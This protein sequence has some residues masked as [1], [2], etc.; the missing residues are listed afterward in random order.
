MRNGTHEDC[1]DKRN[2]WGLLT[3]A[4]HRARA[5]LVT[6]VVCSSVLIAP[7]AASAAVGNRAS[8]TSSA[9]SIGV[10][11]PVTTLQGSIPSWASSGATVSILQLPNL[12]N[13]SVGVAIPVPTVGDEQV[14]GAAY[15]VSVPT[16]AGTN[17]ELVISNGS[18]NAT[19]FASGVSG[20]VATSSGTTSPASGASTTTIQV[21]AFGE[22]TAASVLA[23]RSA[24]VA[25][26]NL[27][28]IDGCAIL[29]ETDE[30]SKNMVIG[31]AHTASD[32]TGEFTFGQTASSGFS[33]GGS[34]SND[35]GSFSA[36]GSYS[37]SSGFG[38]GTP[39]AAAS[40]VTVMA[41][42]EVGDFWLD[43]TYF[44]TYALIPYKWT[45]GLGAGAAGSAGT[46]PNGTCPP[47][48][49]KELQPGN[50]AMA[51]FGSSRSFDTGISVLGWGFSV[52]QSW[53][54]DTSMTWYAGSNADT[55]YLCGPG[56]SAP[57]G[58]PVIYDSLG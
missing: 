58:E 23:G 45:G 1:L 31:E 47:S 22:P 49:S 55:T 46:N 28:Y 19:V 53:G 24:H 17:Y 36:D 3:S 39:I 51:D 50:E 48:T 26:P 34:S 30:G 38:E 8:G 27:S 56:P 21:A 9:G 44:F 15:S 6:V 57:Q 54:S 25:R 18:Q 12:K 4:I 40:H 42:F 10:G 14:S 16:S 43:C 2:W 13:A 37:V 7:V 52:S 11:G 5:A 33:V 35:N 32:V 20:V 41:T 29:E